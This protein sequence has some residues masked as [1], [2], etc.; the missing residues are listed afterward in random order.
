MRDHNT[1]Q[2]Q[3]WLSDLQR[4]IKPSKAELLQDVIALALVSLAV[5]AAL[6]L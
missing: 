1:T 5:I 6:W 4:G 2:R 3:A